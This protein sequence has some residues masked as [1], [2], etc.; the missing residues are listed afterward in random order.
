MN[1]NRKYK[2]LLLTLMMGLLLGL[3]GCGPNPKN[4]TYGDLTITLT[5]EFKSK[6]MNNFDAYYTA[7]HVIFTAR[8]E[9]D[10]VLEYSGFEINTLK[11]YCNEILILNG[12][13]HT[14]LTQRN[15]YYY[16]TNTATVSGASYTYVHCMFE[17]SNSYWIC[18][19]TCKT[20]DYDRYKEKIFEWADS[21]TIKH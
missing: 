17:G 19:F 3:C 15:D 12:V 14:A 11:D 7:D 13:S 5:D 16:F 10:E 21:I 4:F 1:L 6:T 2:L 18:E 8:E 20:K 9:T